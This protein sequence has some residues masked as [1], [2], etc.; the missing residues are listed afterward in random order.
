MKK[1]VLVLLL[2]IIGIV[3]IVGASPAPVVADFTYTTVC[4]YTFQFSDTSTGNPITWYWS[5]MGGSQASP[6][7]NPYVSINQGT[8]T[9]SLTVGNGT[10]YTSTISKTVVSTPPSVPT[11]SFTTTPSSGT[12]PLT[13]QF[14][15]TSSSLN[16]PINRWSW[17]FGDGSGSSINQ[18]PTY[19]FTKTCNPNTGNRTFPVTL[20]VY[21]GGG[22]QATTT[23]NV[24]I[25]AP[26]DPVSSFTANQTSGPAPLTVQF[27]DTSKNNPTTWGWNFGDGTGSNLQNPPTHA[28]TISGVY[29]VTMQAS[30]S[31]TCNP[32]N[33][34]TSTITVL[35]PLAPGTTTSPT[36]SLNQ[37]ATITTSTTL[38]PTTVTEQTTLPSVTMAQTVTATPSVF[39][40]TPKPT[41]T[42]MKV[43]TSIPTSTPTQ[44]SPFG[45]EFS[46]LAISAAILIV[47][48]QYRKP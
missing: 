21:T 38:P 20:I 41:V 43:F 9:V 25:T 28:Y 47:R 30:S 16:C 6:D 31:T 46:I 48:S 40:Y 3:Q 12:V 18:K 10:Q 45:I 33:P 8:Q 23:N 11:A 37:T 32:T 17:S 42:T 7:Q 19:T 36:P 22:T 5:F 1:I 34:A 27:T 13:V 14:T 29:T 35:S 44:K 24:I 39:Y 2:L 26:P 4:G 15:D